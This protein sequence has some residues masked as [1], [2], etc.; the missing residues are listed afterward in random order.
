MVFSPE[1]LSILVL[2]SLGLGVLAIL[3]LAARRGGR[4]AL[5]DTPG[6][7][8]AAQKHAIAQLRGA[9]Q[10]LEAEQRRQAEVLLSTIR[11]IGLV[12]YDAFED[13]GGHLSFSA[14]LL[15]DQGTGLVMTSING[16]QDTRCYAKPVESGA[17]RH[18]LSDEEQEA[19]RQALSSRPE[20]GTP[21]EVAPRRTRRIS[22]A[23]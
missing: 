17:S 14:A 7:T 18:N 22:S 20:L 9:V 10:G 3:L 5:G 6:D 8:L 15:D 2:A 1:I 12:R 13:M 16:R 21:V 19:V 23:T 4:S 11:R